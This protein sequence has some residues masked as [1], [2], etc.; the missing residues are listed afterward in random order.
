MTNDIEVKRGVFIVFEGPDGSGKSTQAKRLAESLKA[1]F[2][3][4]PGG[5]ALG[6]SVR[7]MLLDRDQPK[8]AVRAEALLFAASRAQHAEEVIRPALLRGETVVC[9]RY[10]HSSIAY[11]GFG[12]K[13]GPTF[14]QRL[15]DWATESLWPD[16]IVYLDVSDNDAEVRLNERQ[17]KQDRLDLETR[18]FHERTNA[19]FR[20]FLDN[21]PAGCTWLCV[22]GDG[23]VDDVAIRVSEAVIAWQSTWTSVPLLSAQT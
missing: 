19:A 21:D 6:T 7:S 1:R 5:T 13:L 15:S 10:I 3:L 23:S 12:R 4:E 17:G 9:D 18:D 2:T 16:V 14:I 22:N 8:P 20:T 11:Q